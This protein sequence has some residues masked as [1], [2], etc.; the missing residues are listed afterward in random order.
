MPWSPEDAPKHNKDCTTDHLKK[1]WAAAANAALEEYGDEGKAVAVANAAVAKEKEKGRAFRTPQE[2]IEW[3]DAIASVH[4]DGL[5]FT[6]PIEIGTLDL[7][8]RDMPIGVTPSSYDP[9]HRTAE[10]IVSTG[11]RVR[12][13]DFWTG[14][15]WDEVL[16]MSPESVRLGRLNQGAQLLDGHAVM[17]GLGS[18]IG[19]VMPG[20]ARIADGKLHA[21][22]KFS[23]SELGQRVAQDLQ[24]GI[25]ILVSAGYK[26]HR[27]IV[28]ATVSPQCRT[29]VD[30][31]PWEVSVVT[32]PADA[33]A[34]FRSA[35]SNS[36]QH[37]AMPA[38]K[39]SQAM[40][41]AGQT[42]ESGANPESGETKV[43]TIVTNPN[44]EEIARAEAQR[45]TEIIE[46][47][48]RAGMPAERAHAA[49]KELKSVDDFRREAFEFL[50]AEA[51]KKGPN[52][53]VTQ[54]S[55]GETGG[56]IE[57]LRDENEHR[58]EAMTDALVT[59]VL[60]SRGAT[61]RVEYK[62]I[63]QA[64][65]YRGMGFVEIAAECIGYR[66]NI[67]TQRQA[68]DILYRAF[69]STSDYPSI[70]ENTMHKTLLARYVLA[71]PT[72]R[73]IAVERPVSDFRPHPQYR[74][75]DFPQPLPL[76]ETG[77]I[78]YGTSTESKETLSVS[79]YGIIFAI[80]RQMI[81][82]DDMGGI[83]Q[84]MGGA[85][86]GVNIFENTTFWTMFKSNALAG[87]TLLQDA[88]A[89]FHTDHGNLAGSG[90]L[91]SVTS[92]GTARQALRNMKSLSGNFLNVAPSLI[93]SGPVQETVINQL[94]TSIT[95]ALTTSVN[96]FSGKL[97]QETEANLT[98][99]EWYMLAS[100][101]S[102]PCFVY[103]FLNG[104]QGPRVRTEEPFGVQG[105]RMSLEHDFGVG[106]I[107]YR[108]AY[109]NPGATS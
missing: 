6:E 60:D 15:E 4:K 48:E 22:V 58:S 98:G 38:N 108:G 73:R 51:K 91:P 55:A 79:P 20:S 87:P 80:S 56:R 71:Q 45:A 18:I 3:W 101:G 21:T 13:R 105:V 88:K 69:Q 47:Q 17:S 37:R 35:G 92:L 84:I 74:A 33:G 109:R 42:A 61:F 102:V 14:D 2:F 57:M 89:V 30:W 7:M 93:L 62:P 78:K 103:A 52:S 70:F 5:R 96:P 65:R 90:T 86:E 40:K 49:I 25:P 64:E 106:A 66:G 94:L 72:Y 82:N 99:N 11:A 26:T 24:D 19:A 85:S 76:T 23:R 53:S 63:A 107:D 12:R 46:I 95:P 36:L 83:D 16:D 77:E 10:V 100:P 27:E 43:T 32:V 31:E 75:G 67:R 54:P 44:V 39:E 104:A 9:E 81:V 8:Q 41:T 68:E 97:T 59:R 50:A 1:V 34:A 28:D 29:A